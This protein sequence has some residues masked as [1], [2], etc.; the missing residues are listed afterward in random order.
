V[1]LYHGLKNLLLVP[2]LPL[3]RKSKAPRGVLL[4]LPPGQEFT[5]AMSVG[6]IA[7]IVWAIRKQRPKVKPLPDAAVINALNIDIRKAT[8]TKRMILRT[9]LLIPMVIPSD[10]TQDVYQR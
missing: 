1:F 5:I 2:V 3:I 7:L 10:W 6:G 9:L 8:R 4:G